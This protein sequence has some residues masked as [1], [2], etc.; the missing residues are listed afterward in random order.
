MTHDQIDAIARAG[1]EEIPMRYQQQD[2]LSVPPKRSSLRERVRGTAVPQT[3]QRILQPKGEA[4]LEWVGVN[5]LQVDDYQRKISSTQV[6]DIIRNFNSDTFGV[7]TVALRTNGDLYVVDGQHRVTAIRLMQ[8]EGENQE[9]LCVVI[10]GWTPVQE[11]KFFSESQRN[12]KT[13]TPG[14]AHTADVYA[15]DDVAVTIERAVCEAGYRMSIRRGD[16]GGGHIKAVGALYRVAGTFGPPVLA[17]TLLVCASTWGVDNAPLEPTIN[18]IA[19]FL[20][21]YPDVDFR[22]LVARLRVDSEG[23]LIAKGKSIG[24]SMGYRLQEAIAQEIFNRYNVKMSTHK[25]TDFPG[26]LEG[27]RQYVKRHGVAARKPGA[28]RW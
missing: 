1:Y 12:R 17:R 13:I 28:Q 9:V 20:R 18:G 3:P 2:V 10:S 6:R 8:Q 4:I 7:I 27:V 22:R 23:A 25:L 5:D 14:Q 26:H 21:M 19:L 15:R 16:D 11:A 24:T